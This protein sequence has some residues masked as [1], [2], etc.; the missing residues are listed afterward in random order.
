MA[1]TLRQWRAIRNMSQE[2]LAEAIGK[3]N[4]T[5]SNWET[6]KTEPSYSELV[7]LSLVLNTN[8]IDNILL[9]VRLTLS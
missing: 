4:M 3:T 1:Y 9:P 8:G 6:G 5:I 7:K 2:Q